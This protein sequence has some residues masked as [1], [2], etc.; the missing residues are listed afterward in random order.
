MISY[1]HSFIFAAVPKTGTRSM[2]G[3]LKAPVDAQ[4]H[5]TLRQ[6]KYFMR[7]NDFE[8]FF[9]FAF[10]RNPF[11]RFVSYCAYKCPEFQT[12]PKGVMQRFV[13]EA[14]FEDVLARPQC[15]SVLGAAGEVL[16]NYIGKFET[17]EKDFA[18]IIK[19]LNL[20]AVNLP[21]LNS[22]QHLPFREYYTPKLVDG[23]AKLYAQDLKLFGYSYD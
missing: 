7:A 5:L 10:V 22:S 3:R 8:N 21:N 18:N 20:P 13:D 12:D 16:A 11:D 15:L 2:L 23:V 19:K 17:L 9:K 14:P 6:A 4:E 1:E